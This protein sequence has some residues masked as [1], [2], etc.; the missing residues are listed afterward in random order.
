MA[1]QCL[2]TDKNFACVCKL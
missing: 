2:N 1:K